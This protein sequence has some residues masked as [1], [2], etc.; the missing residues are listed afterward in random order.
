MFT[1]SRNKEKQ[2]RGNKLELLKQDER[3]NEHLLS[4]SENSGC[5]SEILL[6]VD[7]VDQCGVKGSLPNDW[8]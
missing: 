7:R 6:F 1:I 5:Y 4:Q 8:S 3:Y 2:R